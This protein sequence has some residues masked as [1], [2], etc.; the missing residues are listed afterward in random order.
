MGTQSKG[1]GRGG[2][3]SEVDS[4]MM[5]LRWDGTDWQ[6]PQLKPSGGQYKGEG[7]AVT[8][9]MHVVDL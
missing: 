7:G 3:R 4:H 1:G 9:Q 8:A 6:G 5:D 2:A